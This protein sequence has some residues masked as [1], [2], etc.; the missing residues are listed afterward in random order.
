MF[1]SYAVAK[2]CPIINPSKALEAVVH[3]NPYTSVPPLV[4]RVGAVPPGHFIA[5]VVQ[6]IV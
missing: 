2:A 5:S 4:V 1:L 3:K 6:A